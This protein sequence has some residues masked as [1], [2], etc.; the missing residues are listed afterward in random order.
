MGNVN[1]A[2]SAPVR[3]QI[4]G[5]MW[6][7]VGR[8]AVEVGQKPVQPTQRDGIARRSFYRLL[9]K[10]DQLV[11]VE[12]RSKALDPLRCDKPVAV[13]TRALEQ[14]HLIGKTFTKC[15]A[16]LAEQVRPHAKGHRR[17]EPDATHEQ[18]RKEEGDAQQ[19][20]GLG[21]T[22]RRLRKILVPLGVEDVG[23]DEGDGGGL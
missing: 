19:K 7:S 23:E 15:A 9:G 17:G 18:V 20:V 11:G 1:R 3:A 8:D 13:A 5:G 10:R 12:A 22:G 16:Q 2:W 6:R 4:C 14:V 21:A